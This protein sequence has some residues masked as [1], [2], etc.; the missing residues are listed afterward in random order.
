MRLQTSALIERVRAEDPAGWRALDELIQR[1]PE[2][3]RRGDAEGDIDPALWREMHF[4][5]FNRVNMPAAYGGAAITTT[6][7]RRAVM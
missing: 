6:A 4:E 2:L 1:T 5:V 7:L 3:A